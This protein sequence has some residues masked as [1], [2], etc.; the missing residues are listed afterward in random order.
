MSLPALAIKRPVSTLMF[1][2][3]VIL[4]GVISTGMLSQ[5]LFPPI[6]YPKLTVVTNYANAAP[7]EIETLITKPIEEAV[8]STAGLRGITSISREG[9][10]LVIA[11]FGWSQNMDFAALG[12]REKIDLMKARLPRDA[13]EPTVVKFNPFELPVMTLSVSSSSRSSVHLKR[14]ADKWIKDEVE[15]IT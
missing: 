1:F 12:V 9:L 8:G 3:G 4:F 7:E 5:E 6:V 2:V 11:E 13:E 10:S 15:K 14:F